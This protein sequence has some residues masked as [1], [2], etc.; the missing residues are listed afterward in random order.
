MRRSYPLTE[1]EG[2]GM[3]LSAAFSAGAAFAMLFVAFVAGALL[4]I[5]AVAVPVV[6]VV[7]AVFW[8]REKPSSEN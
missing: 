2:G 5:G 3:T 4:V 7:A 6:A 1:A 8:A